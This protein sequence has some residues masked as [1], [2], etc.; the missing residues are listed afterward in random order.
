MRQLPI[1]KRMKKIREV[2]EF[3]LPIAEKYWK[4]YKE[5]LL[6]WCWLMKER[7]SVAA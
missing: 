6:Y 2:E 5:T 7:S 4:E 1:R 3:V